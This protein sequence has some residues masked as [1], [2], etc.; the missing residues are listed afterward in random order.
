LAEPHLTTLPGEQASFLVGGQIPYLVSSGLGQETVQFQPYGV[1]LQVTPIILPNGSIQTKITPDISSIDNA[2]GVQL[3]GSLFPALKESKITTTVISRPGQSI[4][5]GGLVQHV[6]SKQVQEF[7]ILGQLPILGKLFRSTA[8]QDN[9]T[10]VVFVMT[11]EIIN[12]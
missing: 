7:P 2:D 6:E 10:D 4:V 5:L 9:K 3:N 11:P 12:R 1:N 8:Y